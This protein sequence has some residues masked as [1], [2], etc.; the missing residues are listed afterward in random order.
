MLGVAG[1]VLTIGTDFAEN[2]YNPATSEWSFSGNQVAGFALD[3]AVDWGTSAGA[4]ALGAGVGSFIVPPV[5]DKRSA[6][7]I[8]IL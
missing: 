6:I 3:V 2:F 7:D 4:A 8:T 5:A 1:D